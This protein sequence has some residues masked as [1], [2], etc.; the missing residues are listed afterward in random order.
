MHDHS[1]IVFAWTHVTVEV[2]C[3]A[4]HTL[5]YNAPR[6]QADVGGRDDLV[7]DLTQISQIYSDCSVAGMVASHNE[8]MDSCPISR[9]AAVRWRGR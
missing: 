6:G 5:I 2:T 4:G 7:K 3:P 8:P 1:A 9:E